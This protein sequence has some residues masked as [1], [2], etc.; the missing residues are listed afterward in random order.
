LV[1]T[2]LTHKWIFDIKD[3]DVFWCTADIGWVTGHS[4]IVYGPLANGATTVMF[5]GVP[6]YPDKDRFWAIVE[7]YRVTIL[8]TA[9]TAIRT[10]MRWGEEYPNK[11]DLSSLRLLGSVGEPINPEAW[12]W[13]YR[14]I[15]K[16]RCPIVDTWWQTETGHILITPLPGISTLKPG[17]ANRP[18]PGIEAA[19]LDESGNPVP[20]GQGAGYLVITKPWPGMLRTLYGDPERYKQ[21]YWGKFPGVYLTGDGCKIDKDGDFWLLGRI[22]DVLNVS[23]HRISTMEVESALVDHPAVAE[24][25]AIGKSHEVKGQ[26]VS[27]FV[28]LRAGYKPSSSLADEL[29]QHVAKKIGPI[30]RPDDIFFTAELPKTRSGKIMRRLLRDI[31][32]GR[33]LGDTTT[34]ADPT[35]IAQLKSQYESSEGL[36]AHGLL[37]PSLPRR[38]WAGEGRAH[39]FHKE[40][41]NPMKNTVSQVISKE[42][43]LPNRWLFVV[44]RGLD[45]IG[46]GERLRV[47]HLSQ[48]VDELTRLDNPRGDHALHALC[49]LLCRGD[50]HRGAMAR[51]CWAENCRDDWGSAAGGGLS[52]SESVRPDAAGALYHIWGLGGVGRGVCL[53]DAHRDVRQMVPRYARV[54]HGLGGVRIWCRLA[55]R[56]AGGNGA[57]LPDWRL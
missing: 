4:Y 27:A 29:K 50:D 10:F 49:R 23:G 15:G 34:L 21:A 26:A 55:H 19:V 28:T 38:A 47:E 14:V 43:R 8:Y 56:R 40:R 52:V 30:A 32:E 24:A 11:H 42:E 7:K 44:R 18:F 2:A 25:A 16:E 31:A 53:C 57:D 13:Y 3:E 1:G 12:M 6:D 37:L 48:P 22:D 33:A 20:Q 54:H 39:T 17:S 5:E 51:P 46:V 35:V 45:A 36:S 9:P 41:V